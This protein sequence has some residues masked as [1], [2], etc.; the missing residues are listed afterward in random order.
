M[1]FGLFAKYQWIPSVQHTVSNHSLLSL[2]TSTNRNRPGVSGS[3]NTSKRRH[4]GSEAQAAQTGRCAALNAS[5]SFEAT[6][7]VTKRVSCFFGEAMMKLLPGDEGRLM[8]R[9]ICSGQCK[10]CRRILCS[11]LERCLTDFIYL[12]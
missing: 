9:E 3:W 5:M 11:R 12:L 1:P 2:Q 8:P 4:S 6:W 7:M 10:E